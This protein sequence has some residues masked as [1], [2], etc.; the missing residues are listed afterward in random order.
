[1]K[2]LGKGIKDRIDFSKRERAEAEAHRR[3]E[4]EI[5]SRPIVQPVQQVQ[6][7]VE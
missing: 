3:N 7:V 5:N 6:P 1:M 4:I 2:N